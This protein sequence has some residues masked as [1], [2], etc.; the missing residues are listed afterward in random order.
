MILVGAVVLVG[1][2]LP[3]PYVTLSPGPVF[4]VLAEN[5][6]GPVLDVTGAPTYPAPG[7]LDLTT[8]SELGGTSGSTSLGAAVVGWLSPDRSVEP[9]SQ[10][11]PEGTDAQ[12]QRAISR[13][14]FDASA[15]TALAAAADH[16]G[17]PVFTE[18]LVSQVEPGSPADGNLESG[19]IL[20]RV[21]G[22]EVQ[23]SQD[24]GRVVRSQQ[25]GDPIEVDYLREGEPG[26]AVITSTSLPGGGEGAYLGVLLID[27]YSSDFEVDLALSGIGGPSA[28]L[29]FA[30]GIVDKMTP[31]QVVGGEHMAGTGSIGPDGAVGPIG[32]IDKKLVGAADAGAA[33]FLAPRD[34]C[35]EVVDRIPAGLEVAAVATLDEALAAAQ[36]WRSGGSDLPRC[37]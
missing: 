27:A 12:Q 5:D 17:R 28:G 37:K 9:R 35:D 31:E 13:A 1:V 22:Q 21:A 32:G 19:D 30:M 20:V 34:N 6:Q 10:R 25:A 3:V 4:D 16:L 2:L 24:V 26:S 36:A 14:V 33:F 11:F 18:V 23:S 15:S 8:V 7:R 29:V